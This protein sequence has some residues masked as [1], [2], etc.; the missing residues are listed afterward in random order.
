MKNILE[1]LEETV[2]KYPSKIA[3]ADENRQ[4]Q[5]EP[6]Y[7]GRLQRC[8]RSFGCFCIYAEQHTLVQSTLTA[9]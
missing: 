5:V 9:F 2:L 8:G 1:H 3:L 4:G 6:V 7:G